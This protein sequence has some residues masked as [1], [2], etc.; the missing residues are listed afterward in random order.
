MSE[1]KD[2]SLQQ[3]DERIYRINKEIFD[4][5]PEQQKEYYLKANEMSYNDREYCITMEN[6][7]KLCFVS[8]EELFKENSNIEMKSA[9]LNNVLKKLEEIRMKIIKDKTIIH[10]GL[11][12]DNIIVNPDNGDV[13]LVDFDYLKVVKDKD[14]L[15]NKEQL[16]S[17]VAILRLS[18]AIGCVNNL[19]SPQCGAQQQK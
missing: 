16:D 9:E 15:T 6:L 10:S 3:N 11:G 12:F 7:K 4:K 18:M 5:L 2:S 19:I 1:H 8:I 14:Y 17:K 13:K